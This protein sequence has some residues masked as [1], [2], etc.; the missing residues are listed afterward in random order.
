MN[1]LDRLMASLDTEE[2]ALAGW[3]SGELSDPEWVAHYVL[4]RVAGGSGRKVYQGPLNPVLPCRTNYG[5]IGYFAGHQL[6]GIRLPVHQALVGWADGC[7]PAVLTRGVPT[8]L[9]LL[10][11]QAQ[12]KRYVSLVDDGV[13]TGKHADPL[14][15]VV[16]DL[17]H[18]EKFADPQHYVEQVGFFSALYG[19]VTNPAWSDLDAE[20]DVMWAEERDYVLADMN[21][22]SIF[23]FL[24]L[25]SRIRAATRRSLGVRAATESGMD[26][27]RRYF[28]L[29]DQVIRWMSLPTSLHDDAMVFS[30]RGVELQAGSRLRAYFFDVGA[31]VLQGMAADYAVTSGQTKISDV[32]C[33]AV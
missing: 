6:K 5:P 20:L 12:G 22:S 2:V 19:A 25:K 14:A 8:P 30:A 1:V 4:W 26:V 9:Q 17:C 13:N 11:L 33:R 21:G 18:I 24:A 23:L 15:F 7:R 29:F 10:G 16:H 27:E 32:I 28:E 3:L 31:A